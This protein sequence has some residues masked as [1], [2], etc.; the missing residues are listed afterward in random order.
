MGGSPHRSDDCAALALSSLARS[1]ADKGGDDGWW[2]HAA[3]RPDRVRQFRHRD[4]AS[5]RHSPRR[6]SHSYR[7]PR[8]LRANGGLSAKFDL[9]K[10]AIRELAAQSRTVAKGCRSRAS[11]IDDAHNKTAQELLQLAITIGATVVASAL[12]TPFTLGIPDAAGAGAVAI[13]KGR[14]STGY[15]AGRSPND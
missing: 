4:T 15:R 11:S 2:V 7:L 14:R 8:C 6:R 3:A 9:A 12:L 5:A 10:S 1:T 13:E